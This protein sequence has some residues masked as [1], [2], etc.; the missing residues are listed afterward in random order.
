[1]GINADDHR[2]GIEGAFI[3]AVNLRN[4]LSGVGDEEL[5]REQPR[6]E[7]SSEGSPSD[8]H[9]ELDEGADGV[10]SELTDSMWQ[11][12]E[13]PAGSLRENFCPTNECKNFP[14]YY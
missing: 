2:V 5:R 6:L 10:G 13:L 4:V 14:G 9:V 1:M 7:H 12:E 11:M 8:T 3:K